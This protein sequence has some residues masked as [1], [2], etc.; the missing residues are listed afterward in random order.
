MEALFSASPGLWTWFIIFTLS[1]LLVDPVTS[2][3]L[4]TMFVLSSRL[5]ALHES[6]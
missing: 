2:L 5:I 6:A 3:S 1:F 4:L